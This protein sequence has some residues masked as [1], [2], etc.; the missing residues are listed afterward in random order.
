M[1]IIAVDARELST[2]TGRYVERL[3]HY[4]Q[5][6]EKD[7]HERSYLVLLRP[8]DMARW[9]PNN[10]RFQPISCPYREFSFGEQLGFT[11][12]LSSLRPDL[13]HFAMPQ[14]PLFYQGKTVTT[15]HDLTTTRFRNPAKNPVAFWVKQRVYIQLMKVVAKRSRRVLVPSEY[16]K[17]DLA[18]F[19]GVARG[20]ITVTPEAAERIRAKASPVKALKSAQ[21]IVYVGR[22]QPHKN[23]R[24]LIDAF[25]QLQK[26][27][28]ALHLA[29][30]GRSDK[31]YEMHAAYVRKRKVKNVVF[32]GFVDEGELR[33]LYEN[34][35][36]YVFP[37]LSEGFGLPGLEAMAHGAPVVSS[38]ATCLPEVYST[39]AHY[40]DPTSPEAIAVAINEVL[41]RPSL[42]NQL[43]E[44]GLA[45]AKE[46]SWERMARQTLDVY[47][48]AL[49]KD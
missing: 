23:L 27:Y 1:N 22:P 7:Q 36:A 43:I 39:A 11:R 37:S 20:Q 34:C 42:R 31:L 2:T 38:N 8:A 18:S 26:T 19:A 49:E 21:F 17:Y 48:L 5:K 35:Q 32:T 16:V 4:L 33:W 46:F 6:I 13:V 40:F 12:Q 47:K 15:V 14:Q 28:P 10:P 44:A 25:A 29:L 41:A 24:R 3:L 45:R 9:Q 30:A